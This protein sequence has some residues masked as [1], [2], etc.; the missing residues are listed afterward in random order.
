MTKHSEQLTFLGSQNV[1]LAARLDLPTA[2]PSAYALFAHCFTCSKDIVAAARISGAL[3]EHGIAVLRF[4]FTGLGRSEGEFA[5]TNFSSN[6]DDVV[7]AARFLRESYRAPRLLIGHSLGG[8]AVLAAAPRIAEAVGVATVNAPCDPAHVARLL[9]PALPQIEAAGE[10]DV[11]IGGRPYRVRRQFLD[12]LAGQHLGDSIHNLGKPLLVFHAPQDQI[13]DVDNARK[14]F[15]A[16]RH[17]KSFVS[18]D[19]ADHL[20]TRKADAVYVAAVLAAWA[21]RYLAPAQD[22]ETPEVPGAIAPSS[23][24]KRTDE[25]APGRARP[26]PALPALGN[27]R[28]V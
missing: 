2:T 25:H 8:T 18:L 5:D 9:Q 16:A 27:P 1:M 26:E 19:D 17:P 6:V 22:H 23:E 14:I 11:M 10:A 21:T 28:D 15:T 24:L 7:A 13:V 4:D 3:A 20:L 12:D